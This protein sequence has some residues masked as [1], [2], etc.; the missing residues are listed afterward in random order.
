MCDDR[1]G[2]CRGGYRRAAVGDPAGGRRQMKVDRRSGL[3]RRC[4]ELLLHTCETDTEL[5]YKI[6]D[7]WMRKEKCVKEF[8]AHV[9][10]RYKNPTD[11][12][13]KREIRK[14]YGDTE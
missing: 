4:A 10:K 6:S 7:C 9:R 8:A 11:T 13:I 2:G 1:V 3:E 12:D 14:A 5:F